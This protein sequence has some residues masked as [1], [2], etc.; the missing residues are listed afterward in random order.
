MQPPGPG[1]AKGGRP[2]RDNILSSPSPRRDATASPFSPRL[3]LP[4]GLETLTTRRLLL[5]LYWLPRSQTGG[6]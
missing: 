5:G 1:R 6:I 2:S 4:L 3:V